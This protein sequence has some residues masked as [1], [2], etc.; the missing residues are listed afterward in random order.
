M[1]RVLLA[2]DQQV[3]RLG[4]RMVLDGE[5]D[6]E[7]VGE[8][9]DGT[10]AIAVAEELRPDVVLMD[11]RMPIMDGIAATSVVAQ[12]CPE[13]RVVV[14]TTFEL[15][16]YVVGA[17]RAGAAG[18]LLKNIEPSALI[19]AVRTVVRGD[20]LVDPAMTRSLIDYAMRQ[21]DEPAGA[22]DP[23]LLEQLSSREREVLTMLSRGMSNA[24]VAAALFLGE[25]TV[26]SH[27][28]N[29]LV[30]LHLRSR[31]QAVVLAYETGLVQPG[32]VGYADLLK[33][34]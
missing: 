34:V 20:A 12:R 9:G 14:I 19:E 31:V 25:A 8:V 22:V 1:I 13:V 17:L 16:E 33:D 30:K 7:V 29:M 23:Q 6:I 27:V 24:Q 10:A 26:K 11:V 3:V 2:D 32:T 21:R 28:S 5:D 15:D 18:F 4:F